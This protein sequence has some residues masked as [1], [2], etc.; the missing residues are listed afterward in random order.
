MN[1]YQG[2]TRIKPDG[3]TMRY[4]VITLAFN[5]MLNRP[6][7]KRYLNFYDPILPLKDGTQPNEPKRVP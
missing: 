7:R 6:V 5:S 1:A 3:R 4:S 2:N